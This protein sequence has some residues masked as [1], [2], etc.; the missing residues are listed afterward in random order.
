MSVQTGTPAETTP[1]G[2]QLADPARNRRA[3]LIGLVVAAVSAALANTI[4]QAVGEYHWWAGFILVPGALIAACA[5]PLLIRG[6]GA[7]FFG[8]L[9]AWIG[10]LVL[11]VGALLMAGAMGRGWPLMI[12]LPCLAVAGTYGWRSTHPLVR[13][14]HRSAALLT[15]VAATLGPTFLL[16]RAGWV[17]FGATGWWGA[18]M[19]AAGAV[20]V[21]NAIELARHRM[22][23]RLQAVTL[24]L[25]PAVVTL[26]FGLRFLRGW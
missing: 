16:L 7:A 14:L 5:G 8:Y 6:R 23:Y 19:M 11:V 15:L 1:D 17:D 18:H 20:V 12:T 4:A 10:G 3:W 9:V 13:G 21:A 26:L 22:P 24:S 25:G 2:Q